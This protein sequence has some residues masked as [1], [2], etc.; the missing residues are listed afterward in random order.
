MSN[1]KHN[2][3]IML[4]LCDRSLWVN[5]CLFGIPN[6]HPY[7]IFAN[8]VGAIVL[9]AITTKKNKT[10]EIFQ[11]SS[12]NRFKVVFVSITTLK[13][14]HYGFAGFTFSAVI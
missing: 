9:A 6:T 12:K 11:N 3:T 7:Q 14:I 1:V 4:S 2:D 5:A 8:A 13:G 10:N